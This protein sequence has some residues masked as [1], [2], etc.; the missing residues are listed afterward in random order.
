MTWLVRGDDVL[1][2]A[3]VATT[4]S[5]RA[6]GLIGRK[7][8]PGAMVLP[9][10]RSVHTGGVRM[11]LDIALCAELDDGVLL[12]RKVLTMKPWRL[13]WPRK[14]CRLVIEAQSGAFQR[15]GLAVGD[16]LEVR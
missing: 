5:Q 15:W 9:R 13:S 1:A 16:R 6:T 11:S 14:G 8:Y 10:T 12:V 7:E 2:T 3:E 4:F